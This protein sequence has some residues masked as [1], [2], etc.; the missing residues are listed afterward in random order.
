MA[1]SRERCVKNS[2]R[3][4]A[5]LSIRNFD[6]LSKNVFFLDWKRKEYSRIQI[7]FRCFLT[8]HRYQFL[9]YQKYKSQSCNLKSRK[10][11]LGWKLWR[12]INTTAI[13][14][15]DIHLY[16]AIV[17]QL[18]F[19]AREDRSTVNK[20]RSFALGRKKKISVVPQSD[21]SLS[22]RNF[23]CWTFE[24]EVDV[25][26]VILCRSSDSYLFE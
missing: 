11:L 15:T 19:V 5:P 3:I 2:R 22:T 12:I 25:D 6:F 1:W 23:P 26:M 17:V 7:Q 10:N 16:H 4:F 14:V 24:S 13:F 9:I 20:D 18:H 21:D 8:N